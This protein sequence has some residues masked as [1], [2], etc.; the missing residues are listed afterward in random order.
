LFLV[1]NAGSSSLKFSLFEAPAGDGGDPA[2]LRRGQIE[3]LFTGAQF[4]A[5]DGAGTKLDEKRW[6][7]GATLG[8]D[9]A[10]AFLLDWIAGAA[11]GRTLLACGHR[12]VHGGRDFARPVRIDDA[13]LARLDALS[14]LAPLHQP[15]NLSPI[16][17]VARAVPGLPQVACFDTAFHRTLPWE[18]QTFAIP[19]RLTE[20]GII[21]YGFHGLSYEYVA[22]TMAALDPAARRL[23]VAH[24]GNGASLCAI[25]ATSARPG[26]SIDTTMGFTPI[27]GVPMGT[28]SG[29]LDPGVILHLVNRGGM[30]GAEVERMLLHESGLLGV[31]GVS[32][33]MRTLRAAAATAD[34]HAAQA[35]RL[36][37]YRIVQAIGALAASLRGLDA[38]VF[39]AGIGENDASLRA[40]VCGALDWLGIRLDES[41]NANGAGDRPGVRISLPGTASAWIVPTNEEL[42][43][44]RHTR[45]VLAG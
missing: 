14:P 43:I 1:L 16:R 5:R 38:L 37:A 25:E 22:A 15:H 39:T 24:L 2:L 19:R 10:T 21:R 20:Q 35:I 9:A 8:H 36:F 40:E 41:A 32:S 11:G 4:V 45:D 30:T 13:V 23:V 44:A 27:D 12:V 17:A 6:P 3:S 33:D 34:P 31:S 7:P 28:R 42:M 18:A 29:A 26:R